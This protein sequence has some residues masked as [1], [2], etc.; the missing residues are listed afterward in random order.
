MRELQC[1]LPSLTPEQQSYILEFAFWSPT[2]VWEDFI[3]P[4]SVNNAKRSVLE[5]TLPTVF[6]FFFW[7]FFSSRRP[8]NS[9]PSLATLCMSWKGNT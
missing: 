3:L 2:G 8:S 1:L 4:A 7:L 5:I 9:L 6:W